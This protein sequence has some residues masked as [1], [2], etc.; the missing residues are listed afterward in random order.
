MNGGE[1]AERLPPGI[2]ALIDVAWRAYLERAWVYLLLAGGAFAVCGLVEVAA[3]ATTN[4]DVHTLALLVVSFIADAFIV[5]LVAL[6]VGVHVADERPALR[7]MLR[8]AF[9]RWPAVTGALLL[10][11]V[12]IEF[13]LS[14]GG[15]GPLDEPWTLA[16]APVTWL[17]WG[18][19]GL[20]GPLAALSA[21]QPAIATFTGFGRSL[22]LSFRVV[23]LARL[24]V[25]AFATVVPL[26]LESMLTDVF[27]RRGIPHDA[28]WANLPIDCVTVGPLAALQSVFALDFARRA[29]RLDTRR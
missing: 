6:G 28:F 19:L 26:L 5:T 3:P 20:A 18:A 1:N 12:L 8:G 17:L 10:A 27:H 24:A 7:T 11:Q 29:G 15:I 21:D 22:L 13:T 25:V 16:L 23:N 14:A 2:G 4:T 9:Y